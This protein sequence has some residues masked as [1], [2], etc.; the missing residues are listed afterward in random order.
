MVDLAIS[1]GATGCGIDGTG[2]VRIKRSISPS[3]ILKIS[4]ENIDGD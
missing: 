2:P 1:K 3:G 4:H